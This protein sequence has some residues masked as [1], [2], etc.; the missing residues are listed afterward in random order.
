MIDRTYPFLQEFKVSEHF[1]F[2]DKLDL[3]KNNYRIAFSFVNAHSKN[4]KDDPRYVKILACTVRRVDTKLSETILGLHK[5]TD[6]DWEQF[7][8]IAP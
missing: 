2:R 6:K 7:Y 3:N 8:P 4:L 5:C 1:D